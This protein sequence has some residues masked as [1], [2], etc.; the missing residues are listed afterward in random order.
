MSMIKKWKKQYYMPGVD[1][2]WWADMTKR[3]LCRRVPSFPRMVQIQTRTG[4]NAAC[5]FCP[6]SDTYDKL[7]KGQMSDSLFHKIV[8][9]IAQHNTTHRISPYLMNEPFFDKTI[10]EKARYIKKHVPK[11]RIVLTTNGSLLSQTVVE[12]LVK[13]NPLRALYISM[14][15]LEKAAYEETMRGGLVFEKTKANVEHLIDMRNQH[16]P[17]LKIVVTMVKTNR[18]DAEAAVNYWKSRGIDSKY[19][20]LENRGGNTESFD[21]LNAGDKRVFLDCVRLLKNAYILFNGDMVLC[22]TDYYKTMV[23]GN[24]ADSSIADVWNSEKALK[25]RRDFLRGDLSEIPLCAE[26]FVS[27]IK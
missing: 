26:C 7:P 2:R 15:G 3:L 25:I 20:M 21:S 10:L 22:C 27:T 19:T 23:L 17:D 12:D 4:C 13:N 5:V 16:A 11:A 24:V 1:S 6:Y 18:I 9:E 8:E 14:Q